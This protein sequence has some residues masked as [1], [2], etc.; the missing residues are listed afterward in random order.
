MWQLSPRPAGSLRAWLSGGRGLIGSLS[1]CS[2]HL[3]AAP[4]YGAKILTLQAEMTPSPPA[5]TIFLLTM[6]NHQSHL[7]HVE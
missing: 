7:E 1:P 3:P 6:R 2:A 5:H 4:W